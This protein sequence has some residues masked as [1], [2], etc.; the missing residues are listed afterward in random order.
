MR[1]NP[2]LTGEMNFY[3]DKKVIMTSISTINKTEYTLLQC[4]SQ[5]LKQSDNLV[6]LSSLTAEE[7]QQLLTLADRHE[8]MSLLDNVWEPTRIPESQ[9]LAIQSKTARTVHKAIQL[10]VL[11]ARLTALLA[12]EGIIAVTLKGCTVARFYPVPEF[13]KTTDIDLFVADK[14][15]AKRAVQILEASGFHPSG[16][17]HANHHV[18][19]A[20]SVACNTGAFPEKQ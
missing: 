9:S 6:S 1:M 11:D 7:Y 2:G 20:G 18:I 13:R 17:W 12:K 15:D 8:V 16:E 5:C 19:L 10:Q 14:N 3:D 4:L